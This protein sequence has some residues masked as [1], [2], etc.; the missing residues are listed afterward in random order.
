[1]IFA[2][3]FDKNYLSRGITLYN[4]IKDN[5]KCF[6]FYVLALDEFTNNYLDNANF[7]NLKIINLRELEEF[8]TGLADS[9]NNRTL[10]EYYFTISPCLPLYILNKF[11]ADHVCTLDADLFFYST[12]ES[13]F[14][15]LDEYSVIITPHKF[16]NSLI[17]LNSYGLYNVS[18][19]IFKNNTVALNCLNIWRND[20]LNSCNDVNV[21]GEN[22]ADQKYLDK[23]PNLLNKELYILN[24][25][26]SGIAPWNVSNYNLK[27]INNILFSNNEKVIFFHFHDFKIFNKYFITDNLSAFGYKKNNLDKLYKDYFL[28]NIDIFK[29]NNFF[30]NNSTRFNNTGSLYT[31]MLSYK[32]I[33]FLNSFFMIKINLKIF[34]FLIKKNV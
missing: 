28:K 25:N 13:I 29:K 14:E 10:I 15:K 8:D 1:M 22:F 4:S 16:S 24:D 7:E 3:L 33:Y 19:Q 9:K 17:H 23:W 2:T 21:I 5:C 27:Y 30:I 31:K 32:Y 12:P 20:C 11:N 26:I 6:T 34:T 18:F